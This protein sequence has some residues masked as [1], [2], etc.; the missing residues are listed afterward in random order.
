MTITPRLDSNEEEG[1][2]IVK[3]Q[4]IGQNTHMLGSPTYAEITI[5]DF[6]NLV[7]KDS[8]EDQP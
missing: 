1:D 5:A 3:F 6:I 2:E 8:F 7:F 4:L